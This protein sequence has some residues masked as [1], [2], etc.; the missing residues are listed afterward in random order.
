MAIVSTLTGRLPALSPR[1]TVI[2][3]PV[4]DPY[5]EKV[6]YTYG[7]D[8]V[9]WRKVLGEHILFEWGIYNHPDSPRPV[10]LDEAGVRFLDR[11][12][13]LAGLNQTDRQ[14]LRRMLDLGCGWGYV[15]RYLAERFPECPRIDAMN[16]SRRQMDYC[17]RYLAE[18]GLSERTRLFL[19]NG[20]DVTL[21]PDPEQP[22]DAVVVRG[23][24]THFPNETYEI[25]LAGLAE[26]VRRGGLLIISDTL[27][28]SDDYE[29]SIPDDV[30]RLACANR[31]T[32]QYFAKVIEDAGFAIRDMRVLPSNTDVAHWFLQAR[33]NIETY[34]PEGVT[35]A[36]E[37]LRV[38]AVNMS[39][40]LLTDRVSAYSVIAAR[41]D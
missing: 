9:S 32:P 35:G 31:K 17:A 20:R 39:V 10:S 19:A 3:G 16:I 23:V 6:I 25:C 34:F 13:E 15:T 7:D 33:S 4:I 22:Y 8:P 29:S 37:E 18:H 5:E 14:P 41:E 26:R 36:L 11:Q 28:K 2:R 21:L 24:F 1:Y 40:A 30:D 12:F 38:M 27:F